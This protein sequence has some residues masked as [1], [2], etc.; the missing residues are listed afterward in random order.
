VSMS[1]RKGACHITSASIHF[2]SFTPR[3]TE[4]RARAS[5]EASLR[6]RIL[7]ARASRENLNARA[8]RT[9]PSRNPLT[10][11]ITR[12]SPFTNAG[13]RQSLG[14]FA[15]GLDFAELETAASMDDVEEEWTAPVVRTQRLA[16]ARLAKISF[17]R[18]RTKALKPEIRIKSTPTPRTTRS[19]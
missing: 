17:H 11:P 12:T 10:S 4:R 1:M 3:G 5:S 18:K 14:V 19:P 8:S 2:H 15:A 7:H 16:N 13:G 6:G 9:R